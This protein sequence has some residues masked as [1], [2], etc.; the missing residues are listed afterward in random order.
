V[1]VGISPEIN[2]LATLLLVLSLTLVL[3]SQWISR[4][5]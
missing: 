2:V 1:K 3:L 5:N 4:R